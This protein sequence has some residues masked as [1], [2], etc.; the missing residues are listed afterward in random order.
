[1]PGAAGRGSFLTF[2][3]PK[4]MK[5]AL[6][7]AV[8]LFATSV[9]YA[10]NTVTTNQTGTNQT[11]TASQ[12][13]NALT[14]TISQ[15]GTT[16]GNVSNTAVT[17][18]T[19]VGHIAT[20]NQNT[21][22]KYNTATIAQSVITT[23]V[24]SNTAT[25]NQN[26]SGGTAATGNSAFM[27][28]QGSANK[29]TTDQNAGATN[30][31]ALT[32]QY[33]TGNTAIVSQSGSHSATA[34]VFQG[35]AGSGALG[36]LNNAEV[37]QEGS[38]RNQAFVG[39]L[40][41]GNSAT[42]VQ[43]GSQSSNNTAQIFQNYGPAGGGAGNNQ[44]IILQET[45][46]PE[47]PSTTSYSTF[48]QALILQSGDNSYAN[49]K[50]RKDADRNTAVIAQV[51][52]SGQNA[53]IQQEYEATSNNQAFITQYGDKQTAYA[54]Q[55]K[56]DQN[57]VVINQGSSAIGNSSNNQAYSYQS[58]SNKGIVAIDQNTTTTGGNN[59][60]E[61]AQGFN[62]YDPVRTESNNAIVQ[63]EGSRNRAKL[64]QTGIGTGMGHNLASVAQNGNNNVV[65][66]TA[67][68]PD[69][70]TGSLFPP[71]LDGAGQDGGF[72]S[73]TV[74]QT[75]PG[76]AN[77]TVFNTASL[78]QTGTGNVLN[79][80]QTAVSANNASTIFQSGMTNSAVVMQMNP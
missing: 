29:A 51:S 36:T 77:S 75:S 69:P 54:A 43:T 59:F 70:F 53:Q 65:G 50:Q 16:S 62:L 3:Y 31:T 79:L 34:T 11:A 52:G 61:V 39:Q 49:I 25:V 33:G 47:S 14:S 9:G 74:K 30:G 40:T 17:T 23:G 57:Q 44:A 72:N 46:N 68:M 24:G 28:Q 15:V 66:G 60:A 7:G 80:N 19:G 6:L 76:G 4:H 38:T 41:S 21:N 64:A 73:M 5:N 27:L 8:A 58:Y 22:T 78:G 45:N 63:Q 55:I 35:D 13:G 42:V 2:T 1:M 10:Q 48:N 71:T 56:A 26:A 20:V 12:S 37:Y 67:P 32:S 18:Q